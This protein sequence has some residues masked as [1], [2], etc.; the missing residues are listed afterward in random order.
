MEVSVANGGDDFGERIEV[1]GREAAEARALLAES[2]RRQAAVPHI[3][4][5]GLEGAA[6]GKLVPLGP[7]EPPGSSTIRSFFPV[8]YN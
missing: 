5:R 7:F 6:L 4:R 8:S 3:G 1:I 2:W